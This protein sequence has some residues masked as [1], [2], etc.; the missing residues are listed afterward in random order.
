MNKN[1]SNP[2]PAEDPIEAAASHL[3]EAKAALKTAMASS[4][5]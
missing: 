2:P 3:N 1:G 5:A 4:A